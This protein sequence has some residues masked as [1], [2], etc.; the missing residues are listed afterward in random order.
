MKQKVLAAM[1]GGV[2]SSVAA[3]LLLE[4]GFDVRG[5][6]MELFGRDANTAAADAKL[7]AD[8][9]SIPHCT[10]DAIHTFEQTVINY[11]VNEYKSGRTPNPCVVCNRHLK[12]G[13][14]MD[15]A[16][17]LGCDYL[18]TGHYAAIDDGQLKRGAD[19]RKD[20][21]YFLYPL[22]ALSID[23]I[24]FPLGG[25]V[26]DQ[27]RALAKKFNL[28]TAEKGDSQDICFIPSGN[29]QDFLKSRGAGIANA[30]AAG[31]IIGINGKILGRH[32]GIH[33]FTVG[34]RKGLGALGKRMYVKSIN[35]AGN[36]VVAAE[37]HELGSDE[38]VIRDAVIGKSGIDLNKKFGVQIRYRSAPVGAEI[39][40]VDGVDIGTG[41]RVY[42]I[43]G[44]PGP[45]LRIKFGEPARAASPGQSAVIYDGDSVVAGGIIV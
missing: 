35:A 5:V 22:L 41:N 9:L 19:A 21:S 2:D 16:R 36:T 1:S 28:P 39:I 34:Q 8:A 20:Q 25:L 33:N 27:V 45:T 42:G 13:M 43:D 17:E 12:F 18:A 11:F 29:Y 30:G 6:T 32:T 3:A 26:K 38:I 37:E 15:K 14:L 10:V 31:D 40:G 23:K 7:A 24:I 44:A 4:R